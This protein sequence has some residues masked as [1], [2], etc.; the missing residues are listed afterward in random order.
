M[1]FQSKFIASLLCVFMLGIYQ[2][3]QAETIQ[4]AQQPLSTITIQHDTLFPESISY[5]PLNQRFVVGSFRHGAVYEVDANGRTRKIIDD[6]RLRSVLAVRIDTAHHRLLAL[7]SDL[8]ASTR[9]DTATVKQ[10]AVLGIYDL[11][12]GKVLQF[13]DLSHLLP[14]TLH[15]VNGMT[16]DSAGNAYITDSFAAAI[17]KVTLNGV[18]SVFLQ[19]DAFDGKGINL[20][21]IVYHPDG[22]LLAVNKSSGVLFKIPLQNPKAFSAVKIGEKFIGADGVILSGSNNIIVIANRVP[23]HNTD[24]AFGLFSA[25]AWASATVT[26]RYAFGDVYPTTG[27]LQDHKIFALHSKLNTLI[28]APA[29]D[30]AT[31]RQKAVIEQIGVIAP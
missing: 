1:L 20:N 18:P 12:T 22:Y 14:N 8:G 7:S 24:A 16:L 5:N 21:G 23:Q 3:A 11:H 4:L 29:E 25:D 13:V 19:D 30:K 6:N 31:L 10:F 17:Y 28:A 15:L 9:S 26:G 27:A 2:M